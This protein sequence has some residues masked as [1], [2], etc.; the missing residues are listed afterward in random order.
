MAFQA[1]LMIAYRDVLRFLR[2]PVRVAGALALP[3]IFIG[4]FG[5]SLQTNLGNATGYDFLTFA[6]TGALTLTIFQTTASGI[7]ALVEDRENDF[8][9][10][11]FVAP[12]PRLT[13]LLGRITG[14]TIVA[15]IQAAVMVPFALLLGVRLSLTQL[16]LLIPVS[17]AV[18]LF[19]GAFGLLA[20]AGLRS[21]R[22]ASEILP[23]L[24]FPQF[25]LGGVLSPI[26]SLP[27]VL[28]ALSHVAPL[29]Y[30]LDLVRGTL[31]LGQPEYNRVVLI[32]PLANLALMTGLFVVALA[33][34]TSVFVRTT[35][36]R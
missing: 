22:G 2:D 8:S 34:G 26:S 32:S 28:D 18:C 36:Q 23:F 20:F 9:Q 15:M 4:I 35:R 33:T 17:L 16:L 24:I 1:L 25:F 30:A 14:S 19:G 5:T 21:Q 7:V 10:V 12:I 29:R 13:I 27:P 6:F 3:P 31:S 11:I